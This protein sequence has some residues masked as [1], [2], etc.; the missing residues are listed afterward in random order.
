M[1]SFNCRSSRPRIQSDFPFALFTAQQVTRNE[2]TRNS[3]AAP[4]PALLH[5]ARP[6]DES[7]PAPVQ[8]Y[9]RVLLTSPKGDKTPSQPL[10]LP[11][12]PPPRP[13][14]IGRSGSFSEHRGGS[15]GG[16]SLPPSPRHRNPPS[17]SS[18]PF[19]PSSSHHP[20][21]GS[22]S[23]GNGDS[24]GRLFVGDSLAKTRADGCSS[25]SS[26]S[27]SSSNMSCSSSSSSCHRFEDAGDSNGITPTNNEDANM[28]PMLIRAYS[29]EDTGILLPKQPSSSG[30]DGERGRGGTVRVDQSNRS[31]VRQPPPPMISAGMGAV[32]AAPSPKI[33]PML[34]SAS[35]GAANRSPAAGSHQRRQSSPGGSG[36]RGGG[37]G[38]QGATGS[39]LGRDD[40]SRYSVMA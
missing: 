8:T 13:S 14:A 1:A 21:L 36:S 31:H 23:T 40:G 25:A 33:P 12:S 37:G 20:K 22:N 3:R 27:S 18:M 19:S 34:I 29:S 10:E 26:T 11:Q 9:H 2:P 15:G 7:F 5:P 35:G 17:P 16:R 4:R 24:G 6:C 28:A 39:S 38:G 30:G 32:A